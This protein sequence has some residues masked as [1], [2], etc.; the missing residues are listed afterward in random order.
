MSKL[1]FGEVSSVYPTVGLGWESNA[2][3]PQCLAVNWHPT[4]EART[5]AH[6]FSLLESKYINDKEQKIVLFKWNKTLVNLNIA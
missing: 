6:L 4:S 2:V 5:N 1:S 3:R